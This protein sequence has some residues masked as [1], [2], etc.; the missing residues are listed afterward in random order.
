MKCNAIHIVAIAAA[1][2]GLVAGA[3]G[4]GDSVE[5]SEQKPAISEFG[6]GGMRQ[7]LFAASVIR[8]SHDLQQITETFDFTRTVLDSPRLS[9]SLW[10]PGDVGGAVR[11]GL[12]RA[13]RAAPLRRMRSAMARSVTIGGDPAFPAYDSLIAD[14]FAVDTAAFARRFPLAIAEVDSAF[15]S[16]F[17]VWRDS[18]FHLD[19]IRRHVF[20][21]T[22]GRTVEDAR[23]FIVDSAT[24][25]MRRRV[26]RHGEAYVHEAAFADDDVRDYI[27][28]TSGDSVWSFVFEQKAAAH[29]WARLDSAKLLRYSDTLALGDVVVRARTL[30]DSIIGSETK[31][32]Y[33]YEFPGGADTIW[34]RGTEWTGGDTASFHF[35]Q[36]VDAAPEE[37][38]LRYER[39][40]QR[41]KDIIHYR[42]DSCGAQTC[43]LHVEQR[44][45][46]ARTVFGPTPLSRLQYVFEPD[47]DWDRIAYRA[48]AR[49]DSV[50]SS[51]IRQVRW[52]HIP[53]APRVLGDPGADSACVCSV[54]V[55]FLA[56]HPHTDQRK[57]TLTDTGSTR[58]YTYTWA[59]VATGD[60]SHLV[61]D[62]RPDS[63]VD[64]RYYYRTQPRA[65]AVTFRRGV[66]RYAADSL[67][68][69][70]TLEN[71]DVRTMRASL[72]RSDT[73]RGAARVDGAREYRLTLKEDSLIAASTGREDAGP[74]AGEIAWSIG[75]NGE[76]A[77][78]FDGYAGG[79]RFVRDG[80]GVLAGECGIAASDTAAVLVTGMY[81][82]PLYEGAGTVYGAFDHIGPNGTTKTAVF[83]ADT[84][85][86]PSYVR[87]RLLIRLKGESRLK[88][89]EGID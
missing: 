50:A 77:A 60:T 78:E 80:A 43:T 17:G 13:R 30:S 26:Q 56:S 14:S 34:V 45:A 28:W 47:G 69:A 3:A 8:A 79:A 84:L 83:G 18:V 38:L 9:V 41:D 88:N 59:G 63:T 53:T 65:D 29:A 19:S 11:E 42:L 61:M 6:K 40:E 87:E 33:V 89:G 64:Y 23:L 27:R 57:W 51:E 15:D 21:D 5:P 31:R 1:L 10:N 68:I 48:L 66:I 71:A 32:Q 44:L 36:V 74:L 76:Y 82:D 24:V 2:A 16:V 70:D 81:I 39:T 55:D 49:F 25:A 46:G 52:Y 72:S 86:V 7:A 62:D 20:V 4:C 58:R 12:A 85:R 67:M 22:L 75:E 73:R 35:F 54:V 37:A